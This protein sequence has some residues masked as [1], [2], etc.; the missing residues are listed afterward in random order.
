MTI[1]ETRVSYLAYR[2]SK[3]ISKIR[4]QAEEIERLKK[5][6]NEIRGNE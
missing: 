2:E 1:E 4:E 6:L 3:L 5:E